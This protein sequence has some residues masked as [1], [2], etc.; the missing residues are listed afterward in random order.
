MSEDLTATLQRRL[1]AEAIAGI[2][3]LYKVNKVKEPLADLVRA[4]DPALWASSEAREL[5]ADVLEGKRQPKQENKR[6]PS[7]AAAWKRQQILFHLSVADGMGVTVYAEHGK[8]SS[9]PTACEVVAGMFGMTE[10]AVRKHWKQYKKSG[11][12]CPLCRAGYKIGQ[13]K[14]EQGTL[15]PD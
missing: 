2:V 4:G 9:A 10:P 14:R 7:P 8:A 3:R 6:P 12:D 5:I 1:Q 15:N 13:A 11:E